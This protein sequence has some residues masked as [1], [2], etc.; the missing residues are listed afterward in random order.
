MYHSEMGKTAGIFTLKAQ[1]IP[2][3]NIF[4]VDESHAVELLQSFVLFDLKGG[5]TFSGRFL[6]DFK[7]R[8]TIS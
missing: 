1:F 2:F 5:G 7:R 3:G 4:V 8:R 6:T